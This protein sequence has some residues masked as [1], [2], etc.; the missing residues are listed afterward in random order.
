M[1]KSGYNGTYKI[2]SIITSDI[3]A[4][5]GTC[6][7]LTN[8]NIERRPARPSTLD[9]L[10][11]KNYEREKKQEQVVR[12]YKVNRG[13]IKAR[14]MAFLSLRSSF[15]AFYTISFPPGTSDKDAL[16]YFNN[17]RTR[18]T[19]HYGHLSYIRICEYQ[20]IGTIHFHILVN[21]WM[22]IR[23]VNG[24]MAKT[25]KMPKYNGVDVRPIKSRTGLVKY[26]SKY[27]SKSDQKGEQL[28]M[29]V[30][31]YMA[32]RDVS[33][34]ATNVRYEESD[35]DSAA[36]VGQWELIPV[37]Y[38]VVYRRRMP[39]GKATFAFC[40]AELADVN[41]RIYSWMAFLLEKWKNDRIALRKEVMAS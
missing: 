37:D 19:Q 27:L 3:R 28:T 33:A 36:G 10:L 14:S 38:V 17:W 25:L 5:G 26:L 39:K 1:I 6:K 16:R 34:L 32:S 40:D 9:L 4:M 29:P 15:Y 7:V 30:R 21:K 41:R 22:N 20:R 23:E 31:P 11:G 8:G 35:F 13:K 2:P 18:V 12:T 24:F